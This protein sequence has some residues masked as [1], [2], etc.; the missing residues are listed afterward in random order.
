M[1]YKDPPIETRFKKG[2]ARINRKG[3]PRSFDKLRKLAQAIAL[4]NASETMTVIEVIMRKWATSKD[5]RL[6][7]AFIEYAYGKVPTQNEVTGKSGEPIKFII[8]RDNGQTD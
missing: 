3:R 4:E 1:A 7:Q 5:P 8:E 6:Q 2:D